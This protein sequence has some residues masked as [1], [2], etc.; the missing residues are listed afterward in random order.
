MLLLDGGAIEVGA[1]PL[2]D[3]LTEPVVVAERGRA[4]LQDVLSPVR[5]VP[6]LFGP[7]DA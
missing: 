5:A 2:D 6:E 1:G 7:F 4:N 3:P